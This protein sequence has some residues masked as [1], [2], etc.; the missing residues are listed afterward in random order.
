M[1]KRKFAQGGAMGGLDT[2]NQGSA[3][4]GESLNTIQ[5]GLSGS[6][7]RNSSPTPNLIGQ[8]DADQS[9]KKLGLKKGG[10]VISASRR[11]DG[12]AT[13]GK[14]KGRMV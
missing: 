11:G 3:Q 6:G 7:G 5:E 10:K 1:K 9:L 14:T 4:I 2:V 12:I 8:F 13:K